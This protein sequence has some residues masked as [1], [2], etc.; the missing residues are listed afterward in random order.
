MTVPNLMSNFRKSQTETGIRV[1]YKILNDALKMPIATEEAPDMPTMIIDSQTAPDITDEWDSII[2]HF[3]TNYLVPYLKVAKTCKSGISTE[4][5]GILY[6]SKQIDGSPTPP[7]MMMYNPKDKYRIQLTNGMQIGVG[8][9]TPQE[10]G[11]GFTFLV[12]INGKSGPN[13]LAHD[14]F[15]FAISAA[16]CNTT[17]QYYCDKHNFIQG[18]LPYRSSTSNNMFDTS[19]NRCINNIEFWGTK[20][21]DCAAVLQQN[22]WKIPDN[23]PVKK[24]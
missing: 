1:A 16:T 10:G 14:Q 17:N 9:Y 21:A 3:A 18:G 6:P 4:D 2:N 19:I 23:Y 20:G 22:G 8:K 13:R 12:D 24:W 5:C 7:D 11:D 15:Y